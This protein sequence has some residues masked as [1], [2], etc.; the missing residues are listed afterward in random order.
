MKPIAEWSLGQRFAAIVTVATGL[1]AFGEAVGVVQAF[2]WI[3]PAHRGM[4]EA[5]T[6]DRKDAIALEAAARDAAIQTVLD[7]IA[8]RAVKRDK[9]IQE[10]TESAKAALNDAADK[11]TLA[12]AKAAELVVV[13]NDEQHTLQLVMQQQ[14][15]I[16]GS[17]FDG[18]L[19]ALRAE[20][21]DLQ[22]HLKPPND[23][24]QLLLGRQAEVVDTIQ[25]VTRRKAAADCDLAKLRGFIR[26]CP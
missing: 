22:V 16:Q 2:E 5:E 4:V 18:Q 14:Y 19:R 24:D 6:K 13:Q 25:S 10:I 8:Q 26:S 21:V 15:E 7:S 9:Q 1:A 23:H 12:L 3:L 17:I 20:L 11:A